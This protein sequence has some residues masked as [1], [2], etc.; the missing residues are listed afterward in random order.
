MFI[1]QLIPPKM[2][3]DLYVTCGAPV[4]K[5]ARFPGGYKEIIKW[6]IEHG[7][8]WHEQSGVSWLVWMVEQFVPSLV[9]DS[10][11]T[12]DHEAEG[13]ETAVEPVEEDESEESGA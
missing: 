10:A 6:K 9:E 5:L 13:E 8:S 11:H 7:R 4:K 3:N 1:L 2:M 12:E